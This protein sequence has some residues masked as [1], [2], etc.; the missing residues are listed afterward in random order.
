MV[1]FLVIQNV[2]RTNRA[3]VGEF[4]L[5]RLRAFRCR[6]KQVAFGKQQGRWIAARVLWRGA[7]WL[8]CGGALFRYVK[9]KSQFIDYG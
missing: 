7:G 4:D 8:N 5:W 1:V 6:V 2:G 9:C 3:A